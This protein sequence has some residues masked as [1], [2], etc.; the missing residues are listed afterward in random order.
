LSRARINF[1]GRP[2]RTLLGR[3]SQLPP[4]RVSLGRSL[5]AGSG[6]RSSRP[7][8]TRCERWSGG[9][10]PPHNA[11]CLAGGVVIRVTSPGRPKGWGAVHASA[12]PGPV[13]IT[14]QR[15]PGRDTSACGSSPAG[16]ESS[17]CD[18]PLGRPVVSRARLLG[19]AR[20]PGRPVSGPDRATVYVGNAWAGRAALVR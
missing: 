8:P 2:D 19:S 15:R 18:S 10:R 1:A 6:P 20:G 14:S 5:R 17:R 3:P 7:G 4:G 16:G 13:G 11:A 12:Y 9:G